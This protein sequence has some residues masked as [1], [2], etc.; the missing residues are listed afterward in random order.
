MDSSHFDA[1]TRS[2][3]GPASRRRTLRLLAAGMLGGM[4]SPRLTRA[5]QRSDRDQDGL[6]DDD[7]AQVYGTN[8]DIYDTDG[9]GVGDGEEIWNRDQ[10]LPGPS[11]PLTPAGGPPPQAAPD[12]PPVTC[13][14]FGVP[15]DFDSECCAGSRCCF[16]GGSL[17]T[18]CADVTMNGGSCP[19]DPPG[20]T[21]C[22]AGLTNC[23]GECVDLIT[24]AGN[25]GA[26]GNSCGLA[27]ACTAGRCGA[28]QCSPSETLCAGVCTDITTNFNCG[29]CNV[30]CPDGLTCCSGAC[31]DIA[32]DVYNCGGC[33]LACFIP[34]VGD[35]I[36]VR[37]ECECK[38]FACL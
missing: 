27:G 22:G 17:R 33:G 19:G 26:C 34:V 20:Q 23:N 31:V 15:C 24:N 36:C 25:C 8:P 12:D 29:D 10:G 5:A 18:E 4:L 38:Q 21:T 16:D 2:L 3:A 32:N 37:G 7:E 14:G 28:M 13:R 11:D 1:L 30:V 6:F 9:D 35:A